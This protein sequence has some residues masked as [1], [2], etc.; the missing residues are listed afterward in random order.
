MFDDL[1][2]WHTTDEPGYEEA[3]VRG[4]REYVAEG[5]TVTIVG[6][7]WGVST[8][9]AAKEVGSGGT[10]VTFEGAGEQVDN[11][12]ETVRLNGVH[13]SV[14]VRHATIGRAVHLRGKSDGGEQLTPTELPE[15]DVLVSDSEGAEI[16]ILQDMN[17]HPNTII[18]ET[19]GWFGASED[20]VR[21]VLNDSGY[22]VV[23]RDVAE[24]RVRD[25][26]EKKGVF[27]LVAKS[28]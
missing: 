22:H 16:E 26:C 8:V 19:H 15:C 2:P 3:I 12:T 28:T 23:S 25:Y 14:T 10:V 24:T 5:D 13:D 21:E 11:V 27:V 1:V 4:I 6:G 9:M 17:I 18:V 7:G 20:E